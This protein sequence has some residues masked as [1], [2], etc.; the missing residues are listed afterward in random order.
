MQAELLFGYLSKIMQLT[1]KELSVPVRAAGISPMDV[2]HAM[3]RWSLTR[4]VE[5]AK[6]VHS[7]GWIPDADATD[8]FN[9]VVLT[10]ERMVS[11]SVRERRPI[12]IENFQLGLSRDHP[13]T[14]FLC[15]CADNICAS[16]DVEDEVRPLASIIMQL[17][18]SQ[19]QVRLYQALQ[20][21]P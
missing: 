20:A 17:T 13:W 10:Y 5:R 6:V 19:V 4:A 1:E 3:T 7:P 14:G 8:I 21:L 11:A 15:Y 16:L 2:L 12:P 9:S 18:V